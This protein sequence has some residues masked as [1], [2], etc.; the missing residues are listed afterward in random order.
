MLSIVACL[1]EMGRFPYIRTVEI[2][3]KWFP[4]EDT[5]N[6]RTEAEAPATRTWE[7]FYR[8]SLFNK[9]TVAISLE[10]IRKQ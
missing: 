5:T 9:H 2:N 3:G 7:S 6:R 10:S 8:Q 4:V 1:E